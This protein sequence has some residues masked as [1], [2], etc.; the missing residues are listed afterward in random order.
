MGKRLRWRQGLIVLGM[1]L[2][3]AACGLW[4]QSIPVTLPSATT[5]PL[6][7]ATMPSVLLPTM[8][9]P[10]STPTVRACAP[11]APQP[12]QEA[13]QTFAALLQG[14]G[15]AALNAGLSPN[16][17]NARLQE[18]GVGGYPRA[19]YTGEINGDGWP[20][21]LLV[22]VNPDASTSPP[23]GVL[24]VALGGPDG[25]CVA[26]TLVADDA[27]FAGLV[28]H[29]VDDL[30]ADGRLEAV[31]GWTRCGEVT[32][33]ERLQVLAW[34]AGRLTNLLAGSPEFADPWVDLQTQG[35]QEG[36]HVAVHAEGIPGG[37]GPARAYTRIYAY[38]PVRDAWRLMET[39]WAPP[40]TRI[41]LLH[42]ADRA[43]RH[44]D[45]MQALLLYGQVIASQEVRD[46]ALP[47]AG[48][49]ARLHAVLA[50][51]ARFRMLV[52]HARAGREAIAQATYTELRQAVDDDPALVPYFEMATA[53]WQVYRQ[54]GW[55]AACEA[56]RRYAQE[57]AEAVLEP[58][59]PEV[60]GTN[61]RAYTPEDVCL[62][63]E[64]SP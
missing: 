38:D 10:E 5:A 44:G 32:C 63:G 15:V 7:T 55:D 56:A 2:G 50:A 43:A 24:L 23:V 59:G 62:S 60:Y 25:Y 11:V 61:N 58:L 19:V 22:L 31:I 36:Y 20:D 57:H 45:L 27:D 35:G 47:G 41:H 21:A 40:Q 49:P 28:V 17:L 3:L 12:F 30:D 33:T 48:E 26:Q 6:A 13:Q 34:R 29:A 51:Y 9:P 52:L 8:A 54:S 46:K 4:S 53:F 18:A 39:Q 37:T 1:F 16:D 64:T 14:A 42:D